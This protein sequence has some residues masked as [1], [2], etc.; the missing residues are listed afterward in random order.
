MGRR[1]FFHEVLAP[2]LEGHADLLVEGP[3]LC[4]PLNLVLLEEADTP[5]LPAFILVGFFHLL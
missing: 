3:G 2:I 4:G 1:K 5:S